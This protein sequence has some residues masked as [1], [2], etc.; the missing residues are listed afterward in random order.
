[1]QKKKVMIGLIVIQRRIGNQRNPIRNNT[2]Y[3]PADRF[4]SQTNIDTIY[5]LLRHLNAN[6]NPTYELLLPDEAS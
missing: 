3:S 4:K 5:G 2:G 6:P 1:M